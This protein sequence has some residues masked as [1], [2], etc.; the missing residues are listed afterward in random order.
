MEAIIRTN[1]R[2]AFNSLIRFLKS[3]NFE[4]ETKEEK[5]NIVNTPKNKNS[6][7]SVFSTKDINELCEEISLPID[8][9]KFQKNIRNEW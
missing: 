5:S 1:D 9:L 6:K 7:K 8:P 4:I 3:L 2:N